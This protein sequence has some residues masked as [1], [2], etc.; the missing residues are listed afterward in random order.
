MCTP[1]TPA[2]RLFWPALTCTNGASNLALSWL[3]HPI[4]RP[5]LWKI[6]AVL[7]QKSAY[8]GALVYSLV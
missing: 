4:I 6:A 7:T 5:I 1:L 2:T 3:I 8:R